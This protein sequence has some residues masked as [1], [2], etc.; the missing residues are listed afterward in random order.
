[1]WLLPAP[2]GPRC[3][4]EPGRHDLPG[5]YSTGEVDELLLLLQRFLP[6]QPSSVRL[7]GRALRRSTGQ[8]TAG[9]PAGVV[10]VDLET[11][12]DDEQSAVLA[13]LPARWVLVH[14][15]SRADGEPAWL[16]RL[17]KPP[18]VSALRACLAAPD[19][20]LAAFGVEGLD[21]QQ[22]AL[23]TEDPVE[24]LGLVEAT[25]DH[26]LRYAPEGLGATDWTRSLDR[27]TG[28]RLAA[29]L[30][31]L[32]QDEVRLALE[33]LLCLGPQ[34]A[35]ALRG[36]GL[37]YGPD[38]EL[39]L[40]P[41]ARQADRAGTCAGLLAALPS[42][43][44]SETARCKAVGLL[45]TELVLVSPSTQLPPPIRDGVQPSHMT[46]GR[47]LRAQLPADSPQVLR[48]ALGTLDRLEEWDILDPAEAGEIVGRQL[49]V[50][51][52]L[53][54]APPGLQT[55]ARLVGLAL[56]LAGVRQ[57]DQLDSQERALAELERLLGATPTGWHRLL[58]AE[59]TWTAAVLHLKY[60]RHAS[61]VDR[62]EELALAVLE[63]LADDGDVESRI[64]AFTA[65]AVAE[66]ALFRG[67]PG[68]AIQ[69]LREDV[70]PTFERLGEERQ[71]A[72][73][74]GRLAAALGVQG[75]SD[76]ALRLL[77]EDVVPTYERLG[78]PKDR[79]A[80]LAAVAD[81][82]IS[83]GDLNDALSILSEDVLPILESLSLVRE[84][85]AALTKL[86]DVLRELGEWD[87]ALQVLRE[88]VAPAITE[89]G[90]TRDTAA[91][92]GKIAGLLRVQGDLD[93]S[94]RIMREEGLPIH[95]RLGNPLDLLIS[96]TN[97]AFLLL[98][99]NRSP[100][101]REE[102]RA[103]LAD[104]RAS[105]ETL[106]LPEADHIREVQTQHGWQDDPPPDAS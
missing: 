3:H 53:H 69:I 106:G 18:V 86:A 13:E 61:D 48:S 60:A 88:Q 58:W 12:P 64:R 17:L 28:M 71:R 57:A 105:A 78:L 44:W 23:R 80:G 67:H 26:R 100:G 15:P 22:A 35:G 75:E 46:L 70:V 5:W 68:T 39:R 63:R 30:D 32:A 79:A 21:L 83:R 97:L 6:G 89:S 27:A 8:M 101:D 54:D 31:G 25:I 34:G 99:R 96:R 95:E 102:A 43:A 33:T 76:E 92:M 87:E 42:A 104:A 82:L 94:E 51:N 49:R 66:V 37:A 85:A 103:L 1:M 4:L 81:L 45:D 50:L 73:A 47:L 98:E 55:A 20:P 59:A 24:L 14:I 38:E 74:L 91:V 56:R 72:L 9:R 77:Q 93:E 16:E 36:R 40:G 52:V 7:P 11:P 90:S 19:H 10:A 41:L 84:R 2:T 65:L 62:S 29:R